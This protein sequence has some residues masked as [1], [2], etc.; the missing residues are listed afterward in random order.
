MSFLD[1]QDL[2]TVAAQSDLWWL[3]ERW[4]YECDVLLDTV[5]LAAVAVAV[6]LLLKRGK[7]D[8]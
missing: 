7:I 1:V 6:G 5:E 3:I 2:A 8:L 4:Y